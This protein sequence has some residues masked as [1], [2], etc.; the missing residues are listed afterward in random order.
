MSQENEASKNPAACG[1]HAGKF[2]MRVLFLGGD[3]LLLCCVYF[4]QAKA[5]DDESSSDSS[6]Q[7]RQSLTQPARF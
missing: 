1:R 7:S 6:G 4:Q 3:Q 5:S 2:P